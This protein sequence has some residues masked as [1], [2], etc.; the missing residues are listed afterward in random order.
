MSKL[1]KDT[2]GYM[3]RVYTI[4]A[5]GCLGPA[6]VVHAKTER[7][8]AEE[9]I[10]AADDKD[11]I[12]GRRL[13]YSLCLGNVAIVGEC[14]A[15]EGSIPIQIWIFSEVAEEV[16]TWEQAQTA[17]E[18]LKQEYVGNPLTLYFEV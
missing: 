2:E 6:I 14:S 11:K 15:A 1:I 3:F 5:G 10:A 13:T 17:I 8:H 12:R 16:V 18:R 4:D 7:I 9:V